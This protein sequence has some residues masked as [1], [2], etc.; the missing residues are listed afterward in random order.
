MAKRPGGY[1]K[2]DNTEWAECAR[3]LYGEAIASAN[4]MG[5]DVFVWMND[6][7]AHHVYRCELLEKQAQYQADL[8]HAHDSNGIAPQPY[9]ERYQ[10]TRPK[11]EITRP[12]PG[13]G[14]GSGPGRSYRP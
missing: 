3:S 14:Q 10:V 5:Q 6:A 8:K 9:E 4:R 7:I 2:S 1:R 11:P 12:G 13:A